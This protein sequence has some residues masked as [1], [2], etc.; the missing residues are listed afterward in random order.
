M[1][2][3]THRVTE[4]FDRKKFEKRVDREGLVWEQKGDF[5]KAAEVYD[6]L[7]ADVEG[8]SPRNELEEK[9]KNAVTSYL[10]MRKA[11]ILL[12]T[13]NVG[14]GEQLMLRALQCAMQ[15]GDSLVMARAQLGVGVFYA[16]ANRSEEG[17]K[18]LKSALQS[19]RKGTDYDSKQGYGWAL[20]NL[21]GFY[22]KQGKLT[23]A[24]E[25]LLK[26]I[27]RLKTIK[28]WVGVASAYEQKIK[29]D[30]ARGD[31]ELARKDLAN[32]IS[33]YE[34]QGM[35]EKANS[36]RKGLEK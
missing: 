5:G 25:N 21:G 8:A 2:D 23:F 18:L 1:I 30:E 27:A 6:Q 12:E 14:K 36:L 35:K 32:A 22:R 16:S 19:F 13:G 15:S 34:K 29:V 11:G 3:K 9:G 24:E 20:L 31:S 7:L 33:F 10:L 4:H 26:A 28:N 17:E